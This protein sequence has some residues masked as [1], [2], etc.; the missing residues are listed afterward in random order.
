MDYITYEARTVYNTL[1]LKNALERDIPL[2]A[3]L[4]ELYTWDSEPGETHFHVLMRNAHDIIPA[5][6][7]GV[8]ASTNNN[9]VDAYSIDED[10]KVT[11]IEIKTSEIDSSNIWKGRE[12]GLYVGLQNNTDRRAAITSRMAASYTCHSDANKLS[13]NMRTVFMITDTNDSHTY[14]DAWELDGAAVMEYLHLSK[15]KYR[16]IKFGSFRK[17]GRRS[18][19]VVPLESFDNWKERISANVKELKLHEMYEPE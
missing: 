17:N 8:L 12:G 1:V 9:G 3:I 2:T 15:N 10:G 14:I 13:K 6:F 18:E 16:S 19:T 11:E 7:L 5:A 4:H